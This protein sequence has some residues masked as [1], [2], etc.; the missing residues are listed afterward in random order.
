MKTEVEFPT[1][2]ILPEVYEKIMFWVDECPKEISGMGKVVVKDGAYWVTEAYLLEQEVSAST[3]D[4]DAE[5]L[6]K[7]MAE[8][9]REEGHLNFWWHS[10][11]NMGAFW[12]G[13]DTDTIEEIGANG[14]CLATVFN[15]KR[16]YRTAFYQG[17][18]D[19]LPSI[20][21]DQIET[22]ITP[23]A[24]ESQHEAWRK[25]MKDKVREKTYTPPT[26]NSY[27]NY[28]GGMEKGKYNGTTTTPM[29]GGIGSSRY[30][31]NIGHTVWCQEL[32]RWV[33]HDDLKEFGSTPDWY[34]LT[35]NDK[36]Q[37]GKVYKAYMGVE[38]PSLWCNELKEFYYEWAEVSTV[39]QLLA[40]E[41]AL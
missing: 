15:K 11:V 6:G 9:I 1:V 22:L 4:I 26:H 20:F 39:E 14:F 27:Y 3:T 34:T 29:N 31:A 38:P 8:T 16:D 30:N 33:S 36:Q 37:W 17:G 19:F 10:H 24:D 35:P 40:W 32:N 41:N 13:T 21:V 25:E 12:S 28:T 7:L 23:L 18:D 5:S 2:H